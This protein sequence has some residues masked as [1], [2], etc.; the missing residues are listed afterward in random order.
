MYVL[1]PVK[2]LTASLPTVLFI[3]VRIFTALSF[4]NV[5]ELYVYNITVLFKQHKINDQYAL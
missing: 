3:F 5:H 4:W 2:K 1:V